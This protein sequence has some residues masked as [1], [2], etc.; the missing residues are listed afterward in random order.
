MANYL[1]VKND[2]AQA[3]LTEDRICPGCKNSVV[4]EHG[5]VV[6]AFG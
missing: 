1:T 5:G 3:L 2:D 4:D 6:V